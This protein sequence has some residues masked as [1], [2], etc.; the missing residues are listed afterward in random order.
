[1]ARQ[2]LARRRARG[3]RAPRPTRSRG[4]ASTPRPAVFRSRPGGQRAAR[5]RALARRRGRGRNTNRGRASAQRRASM[6]AAAQKRAQ[7]RRAAAQKRG[8]QAPRLG[9]SQQ[10]PRLGGPQQANRNKA[11]QMLM[12]ARRGNLPQGGKQTLFGQIRGLTRGQQD[13]NFAVPQRPIPNRDGR[14]ASMQN[15]L[16]A[17]Q[18][19][20]QGGGKGQGIKAPRAQS[21][22]N[23]VNPQNQMNLRMAQARAQRAAAQRSAGRPSIIGPMDPSRGTFGKGLDPR[24]MPQSNYMRQPMPPQQI[25]RGMGRGPMQRGNTGSAQAPRPLFNQQMRQ[26]QARQPLPRRRA[27]P[28]RQQQPQ[29]RKPLARRRFIPRRT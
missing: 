25:Q 19:R 29:A 5:A 8:S 9:G 20:A 17:A 7:A 11:N 27:Q 10:A 14:M 1:M 3:R 2:P 21:P 6:R 28:V 24:K 13:R 18:A 15:D 26:P 22:M 23:K 12:E 4:R 16:R